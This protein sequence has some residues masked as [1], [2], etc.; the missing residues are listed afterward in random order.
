MG[1]T[2]GKRYLLATSSLLA[3][4]AS[5]APSSANTIVGYVVGAYDADCATV[6]CT[7]GGALTYSTNGGTTYDTPSL[8]FQNIGTKSWTNLSITLT[9]YQANNN[10]IVQT[11]NL[12]NIGPNSV[13]QLIWNGPTTADNLFAYDYDDSY[14]GTTSGTD[15]AGH[16]CGSGSGTTTGLCAYVGNFKVDF[17]GQIAG[18]LPISSLFSPDPNVGGGN[19]QG[20]FQCWEGLDIDGYS[21]TYCD[22]HTLTN[23][24]TLANIL[25][26]TG[27]VG[28]GGAVPE[29]ATLAL[30]GAG[31]GA[32]SLLR[33][34]KKK[35]T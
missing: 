11:F 29:P 16:T 9:G 12:P 27:Q 35:A 19:L 18:G 26:G 13:Y 17:E 3:L 14:G 10:G 22:Q 8:F 7:Q 1:H 15:A 4:L 28:G 20:T 32:V 24:G 6:D 2:M 5:Q 34:R 30:A 23:P 21:E 31:L 25:T 33:R